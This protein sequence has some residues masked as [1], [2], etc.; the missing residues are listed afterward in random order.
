ME[1]NQ[2]SF[3]QKFK[4]WLITLSAL[5]AFI[6]IMGIYQFVVNG[7]LS[8]LMGHGFFEINEALKDNPLLLNVIG[9]LIMLAAVITLIWLYWIVIQ[10]FTIAEFGL[11]LKNGIS[12]SLTGLLTGLFL[13]TSI[14]LI[15][16]ISE[17]IEIKAIQFDALSFFSYLFIF[18]LVGFYE[19]SLLRGYFLGT[20]LKLTNKYLALGITSVLFSLMHILNAN[21]SLVPFINIVL[22]GILLGIVYIHTL[23]LWFSIT[24]HFIWNFLQGPVFG[25]MVSGNSSGES[26]IS[27]TTNDND[28]LTGGEFGFEGSLIMTGLLMI[29]ILILDGYYKRR[30]PVKEI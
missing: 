14:F 28:L 25:S 8:T 19:E 15:L 27:I 12:E 30:I 5:P 6:L 23:R 18:L 4:P 22:A 24:L 17:Q 21:F 20:M 3:W 26:V 1:N 13:I 9:S 29:L 2:K 16:L 11:R 10:K 7:L